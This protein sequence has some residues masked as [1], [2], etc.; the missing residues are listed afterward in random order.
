[1]TAVRALIVDDSALMRSRLRTILTRDVGVEVVG[2]AYDATMA[3]DRIRRL[4]PHGVGLNTE[5]Q[6]GQ[7]GEKW[8]MNMSQ[9]AKPRNRSRRRSRLDGASAS[10]TRI[11]LHPR[12]DNS[13]DLRR[14]LSPQAVL[15]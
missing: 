5:H 10:S 6:D 2:V 8:P 13:R 14:H 7:G 12:S 15:C 11:C 9:V 3:L 4:R 1:M